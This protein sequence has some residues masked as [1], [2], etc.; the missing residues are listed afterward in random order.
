MPWQTAA[1]HENAQPKSR[2]VVAWEA[3]PDLTEEVVFT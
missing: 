2:V 1:T 3:P